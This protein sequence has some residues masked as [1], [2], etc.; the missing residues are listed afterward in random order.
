MIK[1]W[2]SKFVASE[3]PKVLKNAKATPQSKVI[4][5]DLQRALETKKKASSYTCTKSQC[6]HTR[7]TA[8]TSCRHTSRKT[9]SLEK[10]QGRT[11]KMTKGSKWLLHE[12][13][14]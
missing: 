11:K 14:I 12:N 13:K 3:H 7:N 5:K 10:A 2:E 8:F 6:S 1:P 9:M 4:I